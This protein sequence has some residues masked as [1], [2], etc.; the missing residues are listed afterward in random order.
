MRTQE[1]EGRGRAD[2]SLLGFVVALVLLFITT[3]SARQLSLLVD[4][5][6]CFLFLPF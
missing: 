3:A 6:I 2:F 1:G 4:S 5:A